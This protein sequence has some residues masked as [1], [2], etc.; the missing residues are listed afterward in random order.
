MNYINDVYAGVFPF[1]GL[2]ITDEKGNMSL[3]CMSFDLGRYNAIVS[4]QYIKG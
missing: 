4:G 1:F 3:N 2:L